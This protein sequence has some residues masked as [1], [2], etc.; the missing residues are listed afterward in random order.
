MIHT[1]TGSFNNRKRKKIK[2]LV[3]KG[4]VWP[5]QQ[6]GVF[7]TQHFSKMICLQHI[8]HMSTKN[9]PTWK[10][11]EAILN[12]CQE[13]KYQYNPMAPQADTKLG[14]C[15]KGNP[16]HC[17]STNTIYSDTQKLQNFSAVITF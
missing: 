12:I 8:S 4:Y 13:E 9:I 5:G 10:Y 14:L 7:R 15:C 3:Y 2:F 16:L 1:S 6:N 17:Y 11:V